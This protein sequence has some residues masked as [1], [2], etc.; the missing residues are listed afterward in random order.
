MPAEP[1][2]I[3]PEADGEATPVDCASAGC[4]N[5]DTDEASVM[6]WDNVFFC[7]PEGK[8]APSEADA[9]AE[10]PRMSSIAVEHV[11]DEFATPAATGAA[12]AAAEEDAPRVEGGPRLRVG[13][14][15]EPGNA[16]VE[17]R[18]MEQWLPGGARAARTSSSSGCRS[19]RTTR[20]RRA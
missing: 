15:G 11:D 10:A 17:P 3:R 19:R 5:F 7:V 8:D 2:E 9:P 20:T 6:Q 12:E 14:V 18:D 1:A 16:R 4:L 13:R